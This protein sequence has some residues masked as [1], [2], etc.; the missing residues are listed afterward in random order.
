MGAL[1][2]T[3]FEPEKV[4]KRP[5]CKGITYEGSWRL[6]GYMP[7]NCFE[8]EVEDEYKDYRLTMINERLDKVPAHSL[9]TI[10]NVYKNR[11]GDE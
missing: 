11:K 5:Y 9:D 7:E 6:A 3:P 1:K 4:I 8:S 10:F 2:T